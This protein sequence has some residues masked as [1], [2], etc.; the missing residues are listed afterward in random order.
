M[1]IVGAGFR[2]VSDW[3]QLI[4]Q[5]LRFDEVDMLSVWRNIYSC[6][7]SRSGGGGGIVRL[8]DGDEVLRV[9]PDSVG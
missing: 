3:V 9:S 2:P 1:V 6:S 5:L 7:R 4:I 8:C